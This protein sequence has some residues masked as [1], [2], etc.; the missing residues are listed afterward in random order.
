MNIDSINNMIIDESYL[1][2]DQEVL[3]EWS[4]DAKKKKKLIVTALNKL[5]S[6]CKKSK[7]SF[8]KQKV[9]IG[10]DETIDKVNKNPFFKGGYKE[11]KLLQITIGAYRFEKRPANVEDPYP[12]LKEI[13]S[14]VN[15]QLKGIKFILTIRDD[16][17]YIIGTPLA[18]MISLIINL[19]RAGVTK[20]KVGL[21]AMTIDKSAVSESSFYD[22]AI[23]SVNEIMNDLF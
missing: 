15:S 20:N 5:K 21:I 8:I 12:E 1:T 4:V 16:G 17:M 13:I 7:N 3:T 14:A 2:E 23:D 10:D 22:N 6:E 9:F 19:I 18:S 11:N